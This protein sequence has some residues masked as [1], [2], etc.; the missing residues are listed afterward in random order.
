[1]WAS[2]D[3]AP[4][5]LNFGTR[6]RCR[7]VARPNRFISQNEPRYPLNER[8]DVPQSRTV[9]FA[10]ENNLLPLRGNRTTFEDNIEMDLRWVGW[11][12]L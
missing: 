6:W 7:S 11:E 9:R 3:T 1:M 2:I 8:S 10:V 4:L 5:I 12:D